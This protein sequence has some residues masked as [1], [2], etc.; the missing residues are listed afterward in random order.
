MLK[1]VL[2]L[3]HSGLE[4]RCSF[5]TKVIHTKCGRCIRAGNIR[6]SEAAFGRKGC[7]VKLSSQTITIQKQSHYFE[8]CHMG[9]VCMSY[10]WVTLPVVKY[11]FFFFF[12]SKHH[13]ELLFYPVSLYTCGGAADFGHGAVCSLQA[14]WD[15][16]GPDRVVWLATGPGW[17]WAP[18][19]QETLWA[20]VSG[21]AWLGCPSLPAPHERVLEGF[22]A[23]MP[24]S[25]L[26]PSASLRYVVSNLNAP[27]RW[28]SSQPVGLQP[29]GNLAALAWDLGPTKALH[30]CLYRWHIHGEKLQ[31]DPGRW[32]TRSTQ[33]SAQLSALRAESSPAPERLLPGEGSGAAHAPVLRPAA[34]PAPSGAGRGEERGSRGRST[35]LI[36]M[37]GSLYR[38][39]QEVFHAFNNENEL[40]VNKNR[41]GVTE[42]VVAFI[43]LEVFS[44]ICICLRPHTFI[45]VTCWFRSSLTSVAWI[46]KCYWHLKNPS[47]C[48]YSSPEPT[49]H[50]TVV[51]LFQIYRHSR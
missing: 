10:I 48:C 37:L 44:V 36:R 2:N 45:P 42:F 47:G 12:S 31:R 7:K 8:S 38:N 43:W 14:T 40:S 34:G 5:W 51:Y 50:N 25:W 35:D 3:S 28:A 33:P 24:P 39:I 30:L 13:A 16:S 49:P 27:R 15:A 17:C 41:F 18:G 46:R 19:Q 1:D 11:N 29:S 20:A 23:G 32:N 9:G 26:T 4:D 6:L 22:L 21:S